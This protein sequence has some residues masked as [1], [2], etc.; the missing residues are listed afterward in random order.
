MRISSLVVANAAAVVILL[1]A[2]LLG[3]WEAAAFGLAV[4][5][6]LNAVVFLRHKQAAVERDAQDDGGPM[7]G[8]DDP[9]SD[10]S[11]GAP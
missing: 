8:S 6:L 10:E 4:L 11:Q 5:A 1:V 9:P 3:W 7:V 2:L